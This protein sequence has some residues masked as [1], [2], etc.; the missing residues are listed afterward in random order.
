MAQRPSLPA[1]LSSLALA[2][3]LAGCADAVDG[4]TLSVNQA[5]EVSSASGPDGATGECDGD[6]NLSYTLARR[7][8]SIR[9]LVAD[10]NGNILHDTGMLDAAPDGFAGKSAIGVE[11]PAG[12]WTL[13]VERDGF[14]GT[15]NVA[16]AC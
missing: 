14:T 11:G 10:G 4:K 12:D 15:Y 7:A 6:G 16:V 2:A 8:G 3:L 5:A 1:L 13:S 9:I